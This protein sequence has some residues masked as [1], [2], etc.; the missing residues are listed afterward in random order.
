MFVYDYHPLASTLHAEHMVPKPPQQD[1][2]TGRLTAVPMQVP[3]KT[4]WSY[5]CQLANAL[6][7]I[8]KAGLSARSIEPSKI[9]HT[10]QN[11]VRINCCSI[12]DVIA[13]DAR[14][15]ASAIATQQADDLLNLGRLILCTA[16]NSATASN[17]VAASLDELA[18]VY[19]PELKSMILWLLQKPHQNKDAEELVRLL[20]GRM[21]D[22]FD[23]ALNYNDSLES[24]LLR[25]LENARLLRLL[26]KLGFINERP[27]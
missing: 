20:A 13:Y 2:R 6:R 23:S 1:R 8:H 5:T 17:N 11:R 19:S 14:A 9:L 24:S 7:C 18:R 22:E 27:E 15:P 16:C 3:E 10:G 12:F 25:E 4:L 26:C 21:A